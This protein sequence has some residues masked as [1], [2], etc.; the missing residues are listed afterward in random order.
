VEAAPSRISAPAG[1]TWVIAVAVIVAD[2]AVYLGVFSSHGENQYAYRLLAA[3]FLVY[4]IVWRRIAPPESLGLGSRH[5][6]RGDLLYSVRIGVV[7]CCILAGVLVIALGA[8]RLFSLKVPLPPGQFK[9]TEEFFPFILHACVMA[10]FVEEFIYRGIFVGL[11]LERWG[12]RPTMAA[13]GI[14]FLG[15][16][17]VYAGSVLH[18]LAWVQYT[19]AGALLAW[20][21]A[22]RRSL[23]SVV[24]LHAL[25]NL[26]V[27]LQYWVM[28]RWP[29][30]VA[31][32]LGR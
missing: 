1:W 25:G 12:L 17:M 19:I 23:L 14:L 24:L 5:S 22:R 21:F 27:A 30:A 16:H 4:W 3:V 7:V 9:S 8:I 31:D 11:T 28:L 2:W 26:L 15:L 18:P 10:P 29:G 6:I 20:V 32:L 13:S